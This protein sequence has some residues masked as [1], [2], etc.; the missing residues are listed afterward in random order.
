MIMIE[1]ITSL[2]RL[3]FET[4]HSDHCDGKIGANKKAEVI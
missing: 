2:V 3:I 1:K 4:P